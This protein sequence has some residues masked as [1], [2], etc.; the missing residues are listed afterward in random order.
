M[1]K[2]LLQLSRI[3]FAFDRDI[4]R[5]SGRTNAVSS[6]ERCRYS[7]NHVVVNGLDVAVCAFVRIEA[8]LTGKIVGYAARYRMDQILVVLIVGGCGKVGNYPSQG[9]GNNATDQGIVHVADRVDLCE[10]IPANRIIYLFYLKITICRIILLLL[11]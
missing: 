9:D 7:R 3:N 8:L 10:E 2:F 11:L 1:Y 5:V 6:R 4:L